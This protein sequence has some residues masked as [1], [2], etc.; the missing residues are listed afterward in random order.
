MTY[1]QKILDSHRLKAKNDNRSFEMLYE[2]ASESVSTR[3]FKNALKMHSREGIAVIAEIKRR[4]PSKGNLF[5]DLDPGVLA[6]EYESGGAAAISVLTDKENFGGSDE[7]L[8]EASKV[9]KIPVLRKDLN[10]P[11]IPGLRL[12]ILKDLDKLLTCIS[13]KRFY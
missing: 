6:A 8:I 4:S 1:L 13:I 2:K 5:A 7:D 3:G 11:L 12:N 10:A 9:I